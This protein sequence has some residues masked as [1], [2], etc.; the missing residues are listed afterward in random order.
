MFGGDISFSG[1]VRYNM[2]NGRCTYNESFSKIRKYLKMADYAV[3][4]LESPLSEIEDIYT[5]K[6]LDRNKV[7]YLIA[8]KNSAEALS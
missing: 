8:D 1:I 5:E 4:N 3:A 2:K 6:P 7:T